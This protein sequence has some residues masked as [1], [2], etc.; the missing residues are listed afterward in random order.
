[1]AWM[2]E[3]KLWSRLEGLSCG[4]T[5]TAWVLSSYLPKVLLFFGLISL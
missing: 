3:D 4:V 1:M 5:G 2:E